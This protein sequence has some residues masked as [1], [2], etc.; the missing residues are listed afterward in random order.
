MKTYSS[1]LLLFGEHIVIKGARALAMPY[2]GFQG[3]WS[4]NADDRRMQ[5]SLP[6]F[7]RYI[8]AK[9][10]LAEAL[11]YAAFEQ[12][13]EKG[14]YFEANIPTGYGLGSSGALCAA[15]YDRFAKQEID[16]SNLKVIPAL[17]EMLAR[18]E[19]FFHQS[20]S[21]VDPLVCYMDQTLVLQ[22]GEIPQ[23]ATI[24]ATQQEA[25]LFLV[26]THQSRK[27][28]PFVTHFLSQ[29]EKDA[30][31]AA[32]EEYLLPANEAGY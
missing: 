28:G 4:W 27:T 31:R 10:T 7:L 2:A 19:G 16:R 6:D 12:D 13:L 30:F 23:L 32:L 15:I 26:D 25:P 18:M 1:K 11:D 5:Q 9:S 22:R 17:Q 3:R 14:L 21:G 20:S 29:Y 24:E 8:K